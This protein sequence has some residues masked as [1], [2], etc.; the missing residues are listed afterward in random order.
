MRQT[1]RDL[2]RNE[3]ER[4]RQMMQKRRERLRRRR[5]R[6]LVIMVLGIAAIIL[7]PGIIRFIEGAASDARAWLWQFGAERGGSDGYETVPAGQ[8]SALVQGGIDAAMLQKLQDAY[9]GNRNAAAILAHPENYPDDL[10]ALL[11]KRPETLDFVLDY[12]EKRNVKTNVDLSGEVIKGTIPLLY[13]WDERWGYDS[14][15]DSI[16]GLAGCGPTCLSM[17][18]MGLTGDSSLHPGAVAKLSEENG[19]Y[20]TGAGT[21]WDLMTLGAKE[22]GLTSEELPL[23]ESRMVQ[24]VQSGHPVICS[25]RPGDFTDSGHFIVLTGY[26]DGVFTVH[27]PN[28]VDNSRTEWSFEKIRGQIKNLWAFSG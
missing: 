5:R 9:G 4:R 1:A 12:P 27:D 10:L 11:L 13:Q 17:V 14:Y 7:L 19:F 15:G 18:A 24:A 3:R 6:R 28:S 22:L 25:M 21:S 8:V 2:D 20:V 26:E 16:V 23:D